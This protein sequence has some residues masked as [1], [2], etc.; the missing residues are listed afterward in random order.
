MK[1]NYLIIGLVTL[2]FMLSSCEDDVV[3]K[4]NVK[5]LYPLATDNSWTYKRTSYN[6]YDSEIDT[7]STQMN[8]LYTIDGYQGYTSSEYIKGEPISLIKNDE[9]GNCI[10]YFFHGDKLVHS[11]V[12]FKKDLKKGETWNYKSVV[13]TDG[14]YS[15]Y[16]FEEREITCIANDTVISTPKGDFSCIG[17]SYHPGGFAEN[18]EPNHTMIQFLS[19]NIGLI[20]LLHYEHNNGDTRLFSETVLIDYSVKN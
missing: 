16:H 6:N 15:Q 13:Y 11:S 19:E 9:N 8:Y 14:D 17:F 20:K 10:E 1:I 12:L 3:E 18:G 5:P 7:Y 4:E 2:L